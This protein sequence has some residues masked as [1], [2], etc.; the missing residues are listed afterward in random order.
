MKLSRSGLLKQIFLLGALL[1]NGDS[2]LAQEMEDE[3]HKCTGSLN[4][5]PAELELGA[6]VRR[7]G[8]SPYVDHIA[9]NGVTYSVERKLHALDFEVGVEFESSASLLK[10]QSGMNEE[11][12]IQHMIVTVE[13]KFGVGDTFRGVC[14]VAV[15]NNVSQ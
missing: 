8:E 14:N 3:N 7:G 5:E 1:A 4:G 9:F 15:P 10:I 6:L 11:G 12:R 2:L 13:P